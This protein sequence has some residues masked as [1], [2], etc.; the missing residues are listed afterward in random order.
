LAAIVAAAA[1]SAA[2]ATGWRISEGTTA[3]TGAALV[4]AVLDSTQPLT[5][6]LGLPQD[7]LLAIRCNERV[8]STYVVW[9]QVLSVDETKELVET[10]QTQVLWRVDDGPIAANFWDQ[11]SDGTGAGKFSTGGAMKILHKLA[12]AHKLVVRMTGTITQDAEFDL[13]DAAPV[14][15]KLEQACGV[16]AK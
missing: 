7:A 5:N 8:L 10:P 9:P 15:A 2:D 3:L 6:M 16:S 1:S 13:T 12:P 11:S 14:I 4:T